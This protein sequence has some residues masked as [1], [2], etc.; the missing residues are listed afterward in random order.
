M[1]TMSKE[2]VKQTETVRKPEPVTIPA[3]VVKDVQD[4]VPW[5]RRI[6]A[7]KK[8]TTQPRDLFESDSVW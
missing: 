7:A 8:N 2:M 5:L 1:A 6:E 3:E 4:K